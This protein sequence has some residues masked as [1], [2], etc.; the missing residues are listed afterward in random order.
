VRVIYNAFMHL[1]RLGMW[2]LLWRLGAKLPAY[3]QRWTERRARQVFPA[4]AQG[5]IVVHAS[6]MG[7]VAAVAGLVELLLAR[8]PYPITL[9]CTTPTGSEQIQKRFAAQLGRRV[10]HVYLPFDTAGAVDRFL[11]ALQ[12]RLLLLVEA[13]LWPNLIQK[14]QNR[15]ARVVVVNARLSARSQKKLARF[16]RWFSPT[17]LAVD[18]WLAQ[19]TDSAR[20]LRTLGIP[21][22]LILNCGNLKYDTALLPTHEQQLNQ[23]RSRLQDRRFWLAASTH[24]GEEGAVLDAHETVMNKAPG[25]V[26]VLAPRHPQRFDG[27]AQL[28]TERGLIFQR[29]S[30]GECCAPATQVW[31]LDSMG[32][33]IAHM[34]DAQAIFIGGSLVA[35]GGHNP[36]EA[37]QFSK[38]VLVGPHTFNFAQGY[39]DLTR[40]GGAVRVTDAPELSQAVLL[41]M[42]DP[43]AREHAGASAQAVHQHMQGSTQ[44]H[45]AH[46]EQ[47]LQRLGAPPLLAKGMQWQAELLGGEAQAWLDPQHWRHAH[48]IVGQSQGRNTVWFTQLKSHGPGFVLRHYHRGGLI[49]KVMG[50]KFWTGLGPRDTQQARSLAEHALLARMQAWGLATPRPAAAQVLTCGMWPARFERCD[51]LMQRIAG[52]RDFVQLLREQ[53]LPSTVWRAAGRAIAQMHAHGVHHSDLNL[54]NLLTDGLN[55]V[56]IIDFDKCGLQLGNGWQQGNLMR[57]KRSLNKEKSL[58]AGTGFFAQEADFEALLEAYRATN[59]GA[60]R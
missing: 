28:L 52:A 15:G 26:L 60:E 2:A 48:Q 59:S 20:A 24:V 4:W 39:D 42:N 53:A 58:H 25:T 5:G 30:A 16:K 11:N 33:L 14:T 21:P 56:W 45:W 47:L 12:P 23:A 54:H 46:L 7:E 38:A 50:D 9:T 19:D 8:T 49:G 17:W 13:E 40:A 44:R 55:Q 51:I 57:L 22:A 1:A 18:A 36:L 37:T 32:D 10:H 6:S 35:A 3:R 43:L 29:Q 41:W 31:L 34:V 27:V